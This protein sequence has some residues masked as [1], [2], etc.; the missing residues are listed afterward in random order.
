MILRLL[1]YLWQLPILGIVLLWDYMT[2]L[3][4]FS[5]HPEKYSLELRWKRV[6]RLIRTLMKILCV[7]Y[8]VSGKENLKEYDKH[9]IMTPNHRSIFDALIIIAISDRPL[10]FA[11]K[12]ESYKYP[13][14]GRI[15]R[16]LEGVFL[17][18][19]DLRQQLKMMKIIENDLLTN[20]KRDWVIFPE[21]TR[22]VDEDPSAMLPFHNGS[23]RIPFNNDYYI[24]PTAIYGSDRVLS[25]KYRWRIHVQVDFGL[26]Y[27]PSKIGATNSAELAEYT[28][29]RVA[30]ALKSI[31]ER[32][33]EF[34]KATAKRKK[35]EIRHQTKTKKKRF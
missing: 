19:E 27:K 1:R 32:D 9:F 22:S 13:F 25:W 8:D 18:R 29:I 12:I 5:R 26:V 3:F 16:C 23:F 34:Q 6:R 14:V 20:P 35:K 30:G 7:R 24:L 21:G 17:D 4:R 28:Q 15:I 10:S 31:I 2:W 11:A 33:R